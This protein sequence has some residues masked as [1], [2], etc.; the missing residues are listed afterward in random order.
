VIDW[1]Q[2]VRATEDLDPSLQKVIAAT[3]RNAERAAQE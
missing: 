1:L 3:V 2:P